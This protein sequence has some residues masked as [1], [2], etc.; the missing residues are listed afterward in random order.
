MKMTLFVRSPDHVILPDLQNNIIEAGY[1]PK[2]LALLS[3]GHFP[4]HVS[5]VSR[6][7]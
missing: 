6:G 3:M 2:I 7:F 4:G 5:M 1:H